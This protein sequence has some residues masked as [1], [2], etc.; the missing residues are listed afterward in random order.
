MESQ[1]IVDPH[2]S[3][4]RLS[5]FPDYPN[6]SI[7]MDTKALIFFFSITFGYNKEEN[8]RLQ[9]NRLLRGEI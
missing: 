3:E 1:C 9:E 5:D 2:L 8:D 7:F 4:P 6:A